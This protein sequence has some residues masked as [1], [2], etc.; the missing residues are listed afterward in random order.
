MTPVATKLLE[1]QRPHLSE[2]SLILS[3]SNPADD[4]AVTPDGAQRYSRIEP[5]VS[6]QAVQLIVRELDI[7]RL[8]CTP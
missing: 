4:L 8:S 7:H 5:E 6:L 3:R 2:V 1:M